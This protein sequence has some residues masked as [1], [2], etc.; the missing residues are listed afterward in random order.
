MINYNGV[1]IENEVDLEVAIAGESEATKIYLRS[2]FHGTATAPTL[3]QKEKDFNKYMKRAAST[4]KII[5]EMASENMERVRNGVWTVAQLVE[6]TQ[7]ADL[8]LVLNDIETLSFEL[9]YQ[10]LQAATNPLLTTDIKNQWSQKLI[11][12]FYNGG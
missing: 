10:K 7:D 3:T 5:S 6:L 4:D 2:E 11:N 9:A 1:L 12:H 8:K